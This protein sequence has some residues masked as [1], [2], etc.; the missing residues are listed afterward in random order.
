MN[1]GLCL[2]LIFTLGWVSMFLFRAETLW[3]A[4]PHYSGAERFWVAA[5][6]LVLSLHASAS[7]VAL[8]L[9]DVTLGKAALATAMF[10]TAVIVWFWGRAQIG[11]MLRPRLPDEPPMQ[12]R[13]DGVFGI[14]RHPLYFAY[15][16]ASAAPLLIV[17]HWWLL[18]SFAACML[19]IAT[20]AIQEERR[21]HSQI[22]IAYAQYCNQVK[23]LVPW[24]W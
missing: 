7:C 20:R 8:T 5:T 23:R 19:A 4:L 16:L 18:C 1:L 22:G 12:L 14:V 24:V 3:E 15:M 10:F 11:D 9:A 17:P 21:M 6:P 13:A 2:S